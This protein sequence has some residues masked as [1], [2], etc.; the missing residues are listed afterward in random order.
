V[1]KNLE[2]IN[3]ETLRA[4]EPKFIN[5]DLIDINYY[6]NF[7]ELFKRGGEGDEH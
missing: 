7:I 2:E 1:Y 5:Y 3:E 6:K 4:F